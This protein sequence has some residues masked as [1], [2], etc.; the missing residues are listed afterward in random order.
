MMLASGVSIGVLWA[1]MRTHVVISIA[2]FN[3]KRYFSHCAE[4]AEFPMFV[5]RVVTL[6]VC[7]I[8][9]LMVKL[10]AKRLTKGKQ[11]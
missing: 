1:S 2:F 3:C 10:L 7:E 5:I 6:H 9:V 11:N 4:F 8:L